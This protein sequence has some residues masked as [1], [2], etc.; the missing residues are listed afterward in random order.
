R[1]RMVRLAPNMLR[2]MM[3]RGAVA[4]PGLAITG[5]PPALMDAI[6]TLFMIPLNQTKDIAAQ[7]VDGKI[8]EATYRFLEEIK[9][10]SLERLGVRDA[11][12]GASLLEPGVTE[13]VSRGRLNLRVAQPF[14]DAGIGFFATT[15]N[16]SVERTAVLGTDLEHEQV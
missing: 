14:A 6:S 15:S 1:G 2:K 9:K 7:F 5:A 13:I 16:N 3:R 11:V 12:L 10:T 8:A 4:D